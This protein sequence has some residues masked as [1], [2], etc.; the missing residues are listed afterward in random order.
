MLI[1]ASICVTSVYDVSD[2]TPVNLLSSRS[3][4]VRLFVTL[5][6]QLHLIEIHAIQQIGNT[7]Y[8]II[9]SLTKRMF[10]FGN[11][12]RLKNNA[13]RL[14]CKLVHSIDYKILINYH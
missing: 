14:I 9:W 1:S 10:L 13:K 3:F 12:Y 6:N 2:V 11:P 8:L 7:K 5:Y 4:Y